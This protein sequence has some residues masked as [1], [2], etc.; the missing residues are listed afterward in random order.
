MS[1]LRNKTLT[2]G[3]TL[4]DKTVLHAKFHR[5]VNHLDNG[6]VEGNVSLADKARFAKLEA[7]HKSR[8]Q[9]GNDIEKAVSAAKPE[10]APAAKQPQANGSVPPA[11]K[12]QPA[13]GKNAK[14]KKHK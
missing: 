11:G 2:C 6:L 10:A 1:E 3:F 8:M 13:K 7:E 12:P 14:H 9:P 4:L 5:I